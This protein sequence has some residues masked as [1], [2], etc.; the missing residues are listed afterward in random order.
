M[1]RGDTEGNEADKAPALSDAGENIQH[2]D[3][4]TQ[5]AVFKEPQNSETAEKTWVPEIGRPDLESNHDSDV[6]ST[7]RN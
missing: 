3:E 4:I 6:L 7:E 1:K 2:A 5:L